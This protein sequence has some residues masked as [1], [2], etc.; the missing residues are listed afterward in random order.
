MFNGSPTQRAERASADRQQL[1]RIMPAKRGVM[2]QDPT[3]GCD[4]AVVGGGVVGL[5]VAWRA[6]QRGRRVCV[7]ERNELGSGASHVAAGMLA[8]VTE[9]DVGELDLLELGLRS[10]RMWTRFAAEL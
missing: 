3:A 1:I 10:A 4:V 7:L 2:P 5:A 8:P 6:A 9:L